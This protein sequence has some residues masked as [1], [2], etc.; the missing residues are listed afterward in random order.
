LLA[1]QFGTTD[2]SPAKVA[3][4][5]YVPEASPGVME[6]DA[7]PVLFVI[8]EHVSLPLRVNTTGSLER[9]AEVAELVSTPVT[10]VAK[11][12]SP[13]AEW[14]VKV[15]GNGAGGLTVTFELLVEAR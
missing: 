3:V 9:G 7:V 5:G 13:V 2:V 14:T 1:N 4:S 8:P 15:V 10:V 11:L 6:H 12:Y